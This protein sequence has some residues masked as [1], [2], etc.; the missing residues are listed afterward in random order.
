[1]A[2]KKLSKTRKEI[3][4]IYEQNELASLKQIQTRANSFSIGTAGGGVIEVGLRGDFANLW[5]LIQPVE[6]VEI[7]QQI[8]AAAGLEVA[9]RPRQDFASWR[10]WDTSLPASVFW[11]G[12]SPNQIEEE[13]RKKLGEVKK[14]Q[15]EKKLLEEQKKE[16]D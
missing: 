7:I 2:Q 5:Y 4:A 6:S 12:A 10:G 11:M 9:I 3:H 14:Q 8:A 15:Q 13:E 1:M 16:N